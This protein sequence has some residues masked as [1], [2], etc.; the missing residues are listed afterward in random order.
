VESYGVLVQ[1]LGTPKHQATQAGKAAM[2][3]RYE[4]ALAQIS[5]FK[6]ASKAAG[7]KKG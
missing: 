3:A 2:L 4:E 5:N 6:P 1:L 7:L